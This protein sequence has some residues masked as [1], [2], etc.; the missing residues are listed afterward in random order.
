MIWTTDVWAVILAV[1]ST[2]AVTK[3]LQYILY[4]Y[5]FSMNF[6]SPVFAT[7]LFLAS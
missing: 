7:F 5:S 4:S 3:P 6:T 2:A 1:L